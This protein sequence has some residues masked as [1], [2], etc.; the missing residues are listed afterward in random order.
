M[1]NVTLTEIAH[2]ITIVFITELLGGKADGEFYKEG[3]HLNPLFH[4]YIT[5]GDPCDAA[6][7]QAVITGAHHTIRSLDT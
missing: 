5:Y 4:S 1:E 2:Q 7:G 3:L 6:L